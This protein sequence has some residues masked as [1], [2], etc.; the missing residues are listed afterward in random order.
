M[1]A[2]AEVSCGESLNG[3]YSYKNHILNDFCFPAPLVP[4]VSFLVHVKGSHTFPSN[5]PTS[6]PSPILPTHAE[7]PVHLVPNK[8]GGRGLLTRL[9]REKS[10]LGSSPG[11][12]RKTWMDLFTSIHRSDAH[13]YPGWGRGKRAVKHNEL[14]PTDMRH[15]DTLWTTAV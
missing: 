10:T 8:I 15:I 6:A 4:S 7:C 13:L 2:E 14:L 5:H 11:K 9:S 1:A 3:F 12:F